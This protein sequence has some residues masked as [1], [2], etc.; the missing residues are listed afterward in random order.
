MS[1]IFWLQSCWTVLHET[2]SG[3][4]NEFGVSW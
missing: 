1:S 4:R 3:A 2:N